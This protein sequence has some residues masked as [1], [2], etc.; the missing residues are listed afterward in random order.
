MRGIWAA[1]AAVVTLAGGAGQAVAQTAY[2]QAVENTAGL[3]GY[4]PFTAASQANDVAHGHTGV[5]AG[6]ASIGG[7]GTGFGVDP[8][9]SSLVLPNA[10][11]PQSYATAG[12]A[13]PLTGGISTAGTVLG[14]I[15][16]SNLPSTDGRIFSIAGESTNGDDFDL[17]LEN[18]QLRLYTEGGA[19]TGSTTIFDS[20]DLNTWIFVAGSFTVGGDRTVYINGVADGLPTTAGGHSDSGAPFYEGQSNVFGDRYFDGSLGGIAVYNTALSATQIK[21]IYDAAFVQTTGS[22][23]E[24]AAWALMILGFGGV[25]AQLHAPRRG[26]RRPSPKAL[27][28]VGLSSD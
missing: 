21:T 9:Q 27:Q 4:F 13:T 20:S 7:A 11:N 23:P 14:W 10:T 8:A 2:D 22:V 19:F 17:Q 16:L 12:G 26:A 15:K 6:Q 18:N 28:A 25:G 24:P 1:A 3:L 5:L